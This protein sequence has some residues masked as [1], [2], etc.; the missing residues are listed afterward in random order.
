MV[1]PDPIFFFG[2]TPKS[3]DGKAFQEE[4]C[5]ERA[6]PH[7]VTFMA[8][9]H[10]CL[11]ETTENQVARNHGTFCAGETQ[12]SQQLIHKEYNQLSPNKRTEPV[13]AIEGAT[14]AL[15][16]RVKKERHKQE[17]KAE[18]EFD[19]SLDCSRGL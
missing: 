4:M 14:E 16:R 11:A 5:E 17:V 8:E 10:E 7:F 13:L 2:K 15:C 12:Q 18:K 3:P 19:K 6:K 9:I 1:T